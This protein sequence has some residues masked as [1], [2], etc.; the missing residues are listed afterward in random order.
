MGV[1]AEVGLVVAD[2][3]PDCPATA[4]GTRLLI[5]LAQNFKRR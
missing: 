1:W 3:L 4:Y 2:K 5:N